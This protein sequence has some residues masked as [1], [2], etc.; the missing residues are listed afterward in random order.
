[1]VIKIKTTGRLAEMCIRDRV[2]DV[3]NGRTVLGKQKEIQ[4]VKNAYEAYEH[5]S[6]INPYDIE[7][8]KRFHGVM[9]KY[10]V[11]ESGKFR[12]GEEGVFKG[13]QCIFMAPPV[14]FVPH[15]MDEL[16]AWMKEVKEDVHPLILSSV[17]P[18]S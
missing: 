14:Q 10:L 18:V 4:E 17:F 2:R 16:F 12:S 6:E 13:E 1:M 3:I 5:L 15:L 7:H 8:L 11:E 9:T